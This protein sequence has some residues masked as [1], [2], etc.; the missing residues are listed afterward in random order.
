MYATTS[1]VA[2]FT[3][4]L[5]LVRLC[6]GACPDVPDVPTIAL[7]LPP[8]SLGPRGVGKDRHPSCEVS[9]TP[10][11]E[12]LNACPCEPGFESASASKP[13]ARCSTSPPECYAMKIASCL[14]TR[15]TRSRITYRSRFAALGLVLTPFMNRI[16]LE[17]HSA[18]CS[19]IAEV[20]LSISVSMHR[21]IWAKKAH[22]GN[23]ICLVYLNF[24]LTCLSLF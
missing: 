18:D 2:G 23:L 13:T 3:A 7:M 22:S 19:S 14:S 6:R 17:G 9:L 10:V 8:I 24:N 1:G 15:P 4:G 12:R 5:L 20:R 16:C 21:R 11:E